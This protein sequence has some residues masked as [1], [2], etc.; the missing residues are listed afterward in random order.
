LQ[1]R[2][3]LKKQLHQM[4]NRQPPLL[5]YCMDCARKQRRQLQPLATTMQ[6]DAL[7]LASTR[8]DD[9]TF[10]DDDANRIAQPLKH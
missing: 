10:D 1:R 2:P 5:D 6:N 4:E 7:I 9:C 3:Q 8:L